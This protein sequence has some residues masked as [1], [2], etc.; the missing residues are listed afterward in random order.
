MKGEDDDH[1]GGEI[2][3]QDRGLC[4]LEQLL[5]LVPLHLLTGEA[6]PLYDVAGVENC[7]GDWLEDQEKSHTKLAHDSTVV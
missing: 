1:H 3:H 2:A 7:A 6:G 5:H 4:Q